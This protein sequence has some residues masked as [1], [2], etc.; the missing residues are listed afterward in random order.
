[1]GIFESVSAERL[2]TKERN[3]ALLAAL[4]SELHQIRSILEKQQ[5]W[6]SRLR[7]ELGINAYSRIT[8]IPFPRAIYD[9]HLATIYLDMGAEDLR[10]LH[11][12][13]SYLSIIDATLANFD[14]IVTES[15]STYPD[16]QRY[17][18]AQMR[19]DELQRTGQKAR[20]IILYYL[21]GTKLQFVHTETH[22]S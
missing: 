18:G 5:E 12:V 11:L 17:A 15:K 10:L 20:D 8:H 16:Y 2:L 22:L 7:N 19:V 3:G 13:Y 21:T 1:M 4:R 14:S 9:R 6:F